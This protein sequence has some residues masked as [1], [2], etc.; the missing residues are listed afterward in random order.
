MTRRGSQ[1]ALA[2]GLFGLIAALAPAPRQAPTGP[3]SLK[4]LAEAKAKVAR[5]IAEFYADPRLAAQDA[6]GPLPGLPAVDSVE[7]WMRRSVDASLDAAT[8][9]DDR[10]AILTQDLERTKAIEARLKA[11]VENTPGL[12]KID[13]FK[14]EYYRLDAEYRLAKEKAGQ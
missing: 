2:L 12:A 10:I 11:I 4:E 8:S 1:V 3:G 7:F 14:A 5:S 6:K 13:T 9:R